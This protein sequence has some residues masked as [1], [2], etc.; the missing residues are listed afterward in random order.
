MKQLAIH[1]IPDEIMKELKIKCLRNN[2]IVKKVVT[3]FL[4]KFVNEK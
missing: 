4:I 3:D 2:T 1:D